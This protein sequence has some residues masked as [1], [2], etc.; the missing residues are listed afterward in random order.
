MSLRL[1]ARQLRCFVHKTGCRNR[2]EALD[3]FYDFERLAQQD[4]MIHVALFDLDHFKQI[5]DQHGHEVGDKVLVQFVATTY[6]TFG[7]QY[8][9][10]RWGG[11]EFLLVCLEQTALQCHESIDNLYIAMDTKAWPN[12][13][14]VTAS[15]GVTQLKQNESI[16][17]A[18]KRADK[19]LYEAKNNGRNQVVTF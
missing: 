4:K 15:T 8:L 3:T 9:L 17:S 5:N 10:Y 14:T 7:E 6:E 13:L 11:E 19:A 2:T 18:I 1:P 12:G 16:R